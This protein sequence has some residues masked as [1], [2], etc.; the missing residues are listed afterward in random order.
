MSGPCRRVAGGKAV[1]AATALCTAAAA[2]RTAGRRSRS[3]G[4]RGRLLLA[5][6]RV[7][8]GGSRRWSCRRREYSR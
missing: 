1:A 2:A 4:T 8:A 5:R 3:I 7:A 6:R